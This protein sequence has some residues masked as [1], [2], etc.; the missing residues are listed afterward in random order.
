MWRHSYEL[1]EQQE[2]RHSDERQHN[3]YSINVC[4]DRFPDSTN[5]RKKCA[6]RADKIANLSKKIGK[7]NSEF[8]KLFA[9]KFVNMH[10]A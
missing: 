3:P 6:N 4:G 5:L 2:T 10:N 1:S 7:F 9:T 8:A